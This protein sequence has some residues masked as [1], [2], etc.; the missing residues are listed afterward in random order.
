MSH[1]ARICA[2]LLA[3]LALAALRLQFDVLRPGQPAAARL[4]LMAGYFTVLTNALV[5][6][7]LLAVAMGWR[8]GGSRAAG[9][10]LSIAMVGA[11]YHLLLAGL[12]A[13]QGLAWWADQGLHTAVPVLTVAWWAAFA[14]KDIGAGDVPRWLSW[15]VLY[16]A[17]AVTRGMTTGFWPYPFLDADT[18]GWPRT[19]LNI[20]GMLLAFAA[21][22]AALVMLARRL[23]PHPR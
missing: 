23:A 6:A 21:G 9:V 18:L 15:P 4:W 5:A 17:Y 3:A 12:H 10:A 13:P 14:P 2:V 22:A 8:I 20:A 16:C 19:M 11:V 1:A 7:H